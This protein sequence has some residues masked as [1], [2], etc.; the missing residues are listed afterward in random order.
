MVVPQN[1]V[2]NKRRPTPQPNRQGLVEQVEAEAHLNKTIS[3]K[4]VP[5]VKLKVQT[6][7]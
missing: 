4:M 3:R 2:Q 5:I 1:M 6:Q 7:T